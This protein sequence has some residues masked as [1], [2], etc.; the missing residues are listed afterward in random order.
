MNLV[1]YFIV[2]IFYIIILCLIQISILNPSFIGCFSYIYILFILVYPYNGNNVLFLLLSFFIGYI[3]DNCLNTG[4]IHAFSTTL[5]AFLRR[6]LLQ[7]FDGKSFIINRKDF[8][9]DELPFIR[10]TFYI[11][12]LILIHHFSLLI[13]KIFKGTAFSII[14]LLRTIFD[15]IFTTILCIVYFFLKKKRNIEKIT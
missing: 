4:G 8:S 15:S 7:F 10:K 9:I 5:S 13:L 14:L 12:S 1:K 2:S 3:I 11:F 6:K